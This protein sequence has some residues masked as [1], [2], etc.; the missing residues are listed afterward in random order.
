MIA[1]S[2]TI[3][4]SSLVNLKITLSWENFDNTTM[5]EK[6][7]SYLQ[8][9]SF[10]FLPHKLLPFISI[11]CLLILILILQWTSNFSCYYSLYCSLDFLYFFFVLF[12]HSPCSQCWPSSI[13]NTQLSSGIPTENNQY[14]IVIISYRRE[15]KNLSVSF[16]ILN[17]LRDTCVALSV[18][19]L[20]QHMSWSS[21]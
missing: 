16:K 7:R 10:Y 12:Q 18:K 9:S 2:V 4:F 8:F 19:P 6:H 15:S 21:A 1:C 20:I 17:N 3:F 14:L 5:S 13:S 11:H